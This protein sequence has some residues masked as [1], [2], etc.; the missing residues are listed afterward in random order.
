MFVHHTANGVTSYYYL[1]PTICRC[2]YTG[3]E[4]NWVAYKKDTS[5]RLHM[6]AELFVVK[7]DM[8]F[9]GGGG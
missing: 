2:L 3:T 7:A 5:S 1:D 9:D 8:P 4:Q 6:D